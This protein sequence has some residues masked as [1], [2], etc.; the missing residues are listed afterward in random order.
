MIVKSVVILFKKRSRSHPGIVTGYTL[1]YFGYS[2]DAEKTPEVLEGLSLSLSIAPAIFFLITGLIMRKYIIT[3]DYYN[4]MM[5]KPADG[6]NIQ[7]A[8]KTIE[9]N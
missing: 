7:Q 9:T 1:Q 8:L 2:S 5:S 3:T 6:G 4:S